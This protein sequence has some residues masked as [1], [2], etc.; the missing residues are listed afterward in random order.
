MASTERSPG[1]STPPRPGAGAP[2]E[3]TRKEG[4]TAAAP[5]PP[6]PVISTEAASARRPVIST[7]AASAA[8][9]RN[10]A[11]DGGRP[12]AQPC[13]VDG[14]FSRF[15]HS[16]QAGGRG[17]GRND[18]RGVPRPWGGRG[19]GRNS[20]PLRLRSGQAP[21]GA[22]GTGKESAT[23]AAP[24]PPLPR[25]FGSAQG[26]LFRP[27]RRQPASPSFRPE[28]RQPRSGEIR[29][30]TGAGQ[31][32]SPV[33]STERSPGFSTPP[34]PGAGA[35][36][37]MTERGAPARGTGASVVI[38]RPVGVA[39]GKLFR[40]KRRQPAS[41]SFRPE[42][43]QPR[44]GEIRPGTGAGQRH[45]PVASTERSPGFSTPPRP[46][47]RG[48]GRNDGRGVPRPGGPGLRSK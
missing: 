13:G 45:S 40:P 36:V 23:A 14:A 2:V 46:G 35:P 28:R 30:A 34:R 17:S 29:L 21:S 41:P 24:P 18:G 10:P 16:A 38:A 9:W 32:H 3:M 7:G 25:P 39:Q 6:L 31:R 33:A 20:L 37:E 11:G 48:S 43:R 15:L 26:K 8:K 1:F 44:S 12:Q 19:S 22:E 27:K 42:R 5:P 47:G 4:A